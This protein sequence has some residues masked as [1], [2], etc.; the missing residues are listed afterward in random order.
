MSFTN[1]FLPIVLF[2][3]SFFAAF[4]LLGVL[5]NHSLTN[6][7]Q[8]FDGLLL[9]VISCISFVV[10]NWLSSKIVTDDSLQNRIDKN[11]AQSVLNLWMVTEVAALYISFKAHRNLEDFVLLEAV[12]F[13]L[14]LWKISAN[15]LKVAE[16]DLRE[17]KGKLEVTES[18]LKVTEQDLEA[19]KNTLKVAEN[20]LKTSETELKATA[21]KLKTSETKLQ[22]AETRLKTAEDKL[23]ATETELKS[24]K[25]RLETVEAE[26]DVA[27]EQQEESSLDKEI[28]HLSH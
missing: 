5:V 20:N 16:N 22:K 10:G 6:E 26:L 9:S 28:Q 3:F 7:V 17:T 12:A 27:K 23:E 2:T 19:S 18:E 1:R 11:L 14:I 15:Q 13:S 24:V 8:I 25:S 21:S 4:V